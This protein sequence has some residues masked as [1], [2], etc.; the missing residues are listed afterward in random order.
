MKFYAGLYTFSYKLTSHSK[1]EVFPHFT[2]IYQS[3]WNVF[4]LQDMDEIY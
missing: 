4:Y 3:Y 2:K 1:S